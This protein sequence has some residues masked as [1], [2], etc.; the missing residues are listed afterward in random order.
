MQTMVA[1]EGAIV[2]EQNLRRKVKQGL[3]HVD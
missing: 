1:G 2:A 3:L